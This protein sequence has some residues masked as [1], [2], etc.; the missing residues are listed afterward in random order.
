M[1]PAQGPL[2]I[3]LSEKLTDSA[4][5]QLALG[6]AIAT[7]VK[8]GVVLLPT[9]EDTLAGQAM[10]GGVVHNSQLTVT[11]NEAVTALPHKSTAV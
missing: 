9:H 6:V 7:P 1:A 11:L 3:V 5:G 2:D 4:P 10:D 8:E